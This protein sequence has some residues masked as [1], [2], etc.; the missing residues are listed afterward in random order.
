M[1]LSDKIRTFILAFC[2]PALFVVIY[3]L[4]QWF[5][6]RVET[7]RQQMQLQENQRILNRFEAD[8]HRLLTL[9][10]FYSPEI[11]NAQLQQLWQDQL[12]KYNVDVYHLQANHL[13]RLGQQAVNPQIAQALI[14]LHSLGKFGWGAMFAGQQPMLIGYSRLDEDDFIVVTR[15]LATEYFAGLGQGE[16]TKQIRVVSAAEAPLVSHNDHFDHIAVTSVAGEPLVLE[17]EHKPDLFALMAW[18]NTLIVL[19]LLLGGVSIVYLGYVW[20]KRSLLSPFAQLLQQIQ[21]IDPSEQRLT[22][23]ETHGSGE[24]DALTDSINNLVNGFSQHRARSR[25]TL[26]AIAEAV[27]VTDRDTKI[28]YMNPQAEKL[29]Q[30]APLSQQPVSVGELLDVANSLDAELKQFMASASHLIEHRKLRLKLPQ[31]LL[32][33]RALTNLRNESGEVIGSVM[34]LRDITAEEQLKQELQRRANIDASTGLLN[35]HAFESKL[36]HYIAHART[37]AVCYL[38]LEQFKLINDNC[39]HVAG[40]RMLKLVAKAMSQVVGSQG[41]LAR[42]GGDEFGLVMRDYSAVTVAR[43][44]KA[45]AQQVSLQVVHHEGVHYRVGVSIGVAFYHGAKPKTQELLKDADI[46]CIAAKRKGSNQI[47]FYDNRDQQLNYERNA[48]KWAHRITQAIET[49][50][51]MLYFQQIRSLNGVSKRQRLEILLRIKGEHERVLPPAQFIAAAERFKLM[52]DVDKEV[53]RKAF[54]WLSQH[55]ELIDSISLSINLSANSLGADGMLD[56]IADQQQYFDVP[57]SCICFEITETSA[58]QNR[59]RAMQ[60][61]QNLRKL[62]FA[63]A[64][65]DFGSGFASYGY[66]RELPVDYVKIDGCFVRQIASNARDFAIVKSIHDV[67]KT[68]GIETVAEFVESTEI[69]DKLNQI[70]I[71]YAQGYAIGRPKPL[72]QYQHPIRLVASDNVSPL[73]VVNE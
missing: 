18:R 1:L 56:Y 53:I 46:A 39:G 40:D 60:M 54:E 17:I 2:V 24:F 33:D 11:D 13:Q 22:T 43:M 55:R 51:L 37:L 72:A 4:H 50:E 8:A 35:R 67:C 12:S 27:I 57:S 15:T 3:C 58:I 6:Y 44:L 69:I 5:E 14:Q 36:S 62:G 63:F 25:I 65:D 34:V 42:L 10:Q 21:A 29:L 41:L 66:L 32:L 47:H 70:G 71:N 30:V 31:P 7:H 23:I 61:L 9:A 73:H 68:M 16:L 45:I 19:A 20:L 59:Q 49:R 38:D 64:L 48:P 52:P 26:E 28:T